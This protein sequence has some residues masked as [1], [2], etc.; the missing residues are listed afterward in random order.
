M[1]L[2]AK[3]KR[4]EIVSHLARFFYV[5]LADRQDRNLHRCKP[6]RKRACKVLDRQ[7]Q[8][9]LDRSHDCRVDHDDP[10]FL[11]L[12]I[13]A[14]QIKALR[15]I[16]IKLYRSNLMLTPNG[17]ASHEVELGTIECR[18]AGAVFGLHFFIVYDFSQ[19]TLGSI[20]ALR[21]AKIL[22][23]GCGITK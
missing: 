13:Y 1:K 14:C 18:F 23:R 5:L 3:S 20:P 17:I 8:E 21:S 16:H 22:F 12:F 2:H 7:R 11:T 10:F 19:H 15:H 6:N 4:L 9:S